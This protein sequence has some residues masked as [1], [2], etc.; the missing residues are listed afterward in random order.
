MTASDRCYRLSGVRLLGETTVT[1]ALAEVYL[2]LLRR[3]NGHAPFGLPIPYA[4]R[5]FGRRT[6]DDESPWPDLFAQLKGTPEA[7]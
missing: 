6:G 4:D 3:W 5:N 2:C 1:R 7:D